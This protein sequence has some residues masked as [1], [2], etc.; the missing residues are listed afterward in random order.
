MMDV[1]ILICIILFIISTIVTLI[2]IYF[3]IKK[4]KY[5]EKFKNVKERKEKLQSITGNTK[6]DKQLYRQICEF[7][8]E[9]LYTSSY[10]FKECKK[11]FT[12]LMKECEN[13][14]ISKESLD[15]LETILEVFI[16]EFKSR[17]KQ[18]KIAEQCLKI[19]YSYIISLLGLCVAVLVALL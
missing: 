11:N 2:I 7:I 4:E 17:I 8:F 6:H 14:P 12:Y 5:I 1:L 3:S 16:I 9:I 15:I 13:K 18:Y 19:V 10:F